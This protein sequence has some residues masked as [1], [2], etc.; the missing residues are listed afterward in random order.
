MRLLYLACFLLL[1]LPGFQ[2][3]EA[4]PP[5][6]D[7]WTFIE[8]SIFGNLLLYDKAIEKFTQA[9]EEDPFY[10]SAYLE[11]GAIY[12]DLGHIDLA[13]RD[14]AMF[15]KL[16]PTPKPP[17][18]LHID[19]W[20]N[21]KN[22]ERLEFSQ[23]LLEGM[24]IGSREATREYI[25]S[26]LGCL[27]GVLFGLWSFVLSPAEVSKEMAHA[28]YTLGELLHEHR[29]AEVFDIFIPEVCE[30]AYSWN[31][32]S[33]SV[34]GQK[35]GYLIGK[36]SITIFFPI[37]AAKG[38]QLYKSLKR[39]NALSTLECLSV[40]SRRNLIIEEGSK[41]AQARANVIRSIKA[42]KIVP[43][44]P[45]VVPHVMQ[46]KHAWEKLVPITG[47]REKDF[48]RVID[49]LEKERLFDPKYRVDV[50]LD[51]LTKDKRATWA[52]Y[53]HRKPVRKEIIEVFFEQDATS[54]V[55]LLKNAFVRTV[56]D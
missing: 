23:G 5:G 27:R 19:F 50:E 29:C 18:H 48:E 56:H 35:M 21:S 8:G 47:N 34:K 30:C 11:R 41:R 28:L 40:S 43:A 25:P 32:W 22:R 46:Q 26:V 51:I 12:F 2:K 7:S 10:G 13:L 33:P 39:A 9:I 37:S 44:N 3:C 52:V 20:N 1:A 6:S 17:L 38:V 54:G 24:W 16:T 49:L 45:N 15:K 55:L 42:G 53:I 14:Y 36:Y 4:R 31:H